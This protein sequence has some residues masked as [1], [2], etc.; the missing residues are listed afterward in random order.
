M[1][2]TGGGGLIKNL[3]KRIMIETGLPVVVADDPLLSVVFGAGQMLSDF[4]LLNK[5]GKM[6]KH[7][8]GGRLSFA[9]LNQWSSK[10]P[11]V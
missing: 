8:G 9:K 10:L 4:E 7:D 3:D 1:V 5:E 6:G 11:N 2:L